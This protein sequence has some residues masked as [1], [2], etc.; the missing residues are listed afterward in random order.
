MYFSQPNKKVAKPSNHWHKKHSKKIQISLRDMKLWAVKHLKTIS[1]LAYVHVLA[2]TLRCHAGKVNFEL[3]SSLP[4]TYHTLFPCV[5]TIWDVNCVKMTCRWL[6]SYCGG[7]STLGKL[8]MSRTSSSRRLAWEK[9]CGRFKASFSGNCCCCSLKRMKLLIIA[10][11][12]WW[13]NNAFHHRIH[14]HQILWVVAI[15]SPRSTA[16][17]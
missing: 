16:F 7:T 9:L 14:L 2:F 6:W 13:K 15:W 11:S 8:Q 5:N 17:M 12:T 10:M 1:F 3:T 4:C